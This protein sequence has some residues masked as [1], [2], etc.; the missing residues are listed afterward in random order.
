MTTF[1]LGQQGCPFRIDPGKASAHLKDKAPQGK[2]HDTLPGCA[3]FVVAKCEV[4][5]FKILRLSNS[6]LC[7]VSKSS[8]ISIISIVSKNSTV[9]VAN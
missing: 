6:G 7:I 5:Q 9:P 2:I 3:I 8:T 1:S 4:V